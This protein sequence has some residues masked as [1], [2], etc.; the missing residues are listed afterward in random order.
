M[1]LG[2][3]SAG[4]ELGEA[5]CAPDHSEGAVPRMSEL[6]RR[7]DDPV[8]HAVQVEVGADVDEGVEQ[9]SGTV[10]KSETAVG[11]RYGTHF[12]IVA[13]SVDPGLSSERGGRGFGR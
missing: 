3:D 7:G 10:G 9:C 12:L 1:L 8:Q 5:A 2:R 11:A 13:E 6:T 4:D